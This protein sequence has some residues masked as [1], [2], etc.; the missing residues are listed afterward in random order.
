MS[1]A[2]Q[3]DKGIV[4]FHHIPKSGGTWVK[5]VLVKLGLMTKHNLAQACPGIGRHGLIEHYRMNHD[6]RFSFVRHPIAWY[7]SFFKFQ[8]KKWRAFEP[9]AKWHPQ[10]SLEKYAS[11]DFNEWME[12]VL[13]NEPGY[14]TR[15]FEWYLGPEG[16]ERVD[17]IGQQEN[18]RYHLQWALEYAGFQ[19]SSEQWRVLQNEPARNVS[20]DITIEWDHALQERVLASEVPAI[21]RFYN[22]FKDGCY[23]RV[24]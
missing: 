13:K 12:R 17:F 8:Y 4:F 11:D 2:F 20:P 5:S 6:F 22:N 3:T 9:E 18:I 10:R 19:V 21:R 16:A 7:E 1:H 14:V 23:E 15:M 24:V